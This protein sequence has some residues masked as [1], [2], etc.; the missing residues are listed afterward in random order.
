MKSRQELKRG[1]QEWMKPAGVFQVKNIIS[2]KLLLGSSLILEGALNGHRFSLTIGSH[3]A[4]ALQHDWN[5]YGSDAFAFEVLEVVKISDTPDFN[6]NDELML[7]EQIWIEQLQPFGERG[8]NHDAKDPP[9][10]I[11]ILRAAAADLS[12]S[13]AA[14]GGGIPSPEPY[15]LWAN[16]EPSIRRHSVVLSSPKGHLVLIWP[17]A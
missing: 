5:S 11:L 16:R 7:L 13:V 17:F 8:Y 10:V 3:R 4:T 15:A 12:G 9:G 6:L 1:Y 2:G 14:I